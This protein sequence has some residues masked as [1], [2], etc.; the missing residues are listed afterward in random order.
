MSGST[1]Y[2]ADLYELKV[3][4]VSRPEAPCVAAYN[5]VHATGV[6]AS[7][8]ITIEGDLAY[9]AHDGGRRR[10]LRSVG[11]PASVQGR[12]DRACRRV[13]RPPS[14]LPLEPDDRS[15]ALELGRGRRRPRSE[16]GWAGRRCGRRGARAPLVVVSTSGR[17]AR[18]GTQAKSGERSGR[19]PGPFDM[20]P[21]RHQDT[22]VITRVWLSRC[23][24]AGRLGRSGPSYGFIRHLSHAFHRE[25]LFVPS[26]LRGG[27]LSG[28]G[29]EG[30]ADGNGNGYGN[31]HE[32]AS[33]SG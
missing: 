6:V 18:S 9:I 32:F 23:C 27:S 28:A 26:C 20:E 19:G 31:G 29:A 16:E 4:D 30:E 11:V 12:A 22:K 33:G 3:I 8:R 24:D 13:E 2:V 5:D 15:Q 14:R 17:H 1:A 21:K 10:D 7:G 25:I